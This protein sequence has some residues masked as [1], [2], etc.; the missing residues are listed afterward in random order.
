MIQLRDYQIENAEKMRMTLVRLG[1]VYLAGAVRTG[2]TLT[3][4]ECCQLLMGEQ[5]S[6]RVVFVTKK[7][8]IGSIE[9]DAGKLEVKYDLDVINYESVHKLDT[10]QRID[11][12]ICDEAH[13]S[14]AGFPTK[15][16]SFKGVKEL[17][18][19]FTYVILLSGT[20]HPESKSQLYH[21][22]AISHR[23]PFAKYTTFYKWAAAF[24]DKYQ[25]DFGYGLV[26]QYDRAKDVLIDPIIAPYMI[27]QTQEDSGF[28]NIVEEEVLTVDMKKGTVDLIKKVVKDRV[29]KSKHGLVLADTA[30]KL[31]QK[32]HQ[33]SSGTIK[34][35]EGNAIWFDDTK[36]KF[37]AE[38]FAGQKIAIM[39]YFKAEF[40]ML[41]VHF[42]EWT[43]SPEVF[44]DTNKTFI[45]QIRSSREGINLSMADALVFM[46]IEFSGVSYIQAKDR[47]TSK[48]R[49]MPNKVY[50]VFGKNGIERK[51]YKVVQNK[52]DYSNSVFKRDFGIE[53]K[54]GQLDL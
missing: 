7:K 19:K 30:V 47:M 10:E 22:F 40:E 9:E 37:I 44:R 4:L 36:A 2:K 21:Q 3:T 51:I 41:K 27:T 42:P 35:E 54:Q 18:D 49:T 16:K 31:Q 43:D 11:V 45:G 53:D 32:V 29:Y 50:W 24:V 20:P 14:I 25:V 39:Y 48:S 38:E 34:F 6:F 1:V 15:S 26:N 52:Q 46:N 28:K 23:S 8:A 17:V 33:M 13:S 5:K 12:L